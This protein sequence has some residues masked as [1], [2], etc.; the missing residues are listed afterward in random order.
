[1]DREALAH[2]SSW[3]C[4]ESDMT[5]WLNWTE[6]NWRFME[7]LYT[8]YLLF[9]ISG[10]PGG[11]NG[12]EPACQCRR[13]KRYWFHPWV[14]KIPWKGAQLPT[15]V[16][17]PGEPQDRG[18]WRAATSIGSQWGRTW[19][20]WLSTHGFLIL[21]GKNW[22]T[23]LRTFIFLFLLLHLRDFS[24]GLVKAL[25]IMCLC[26]SLKVF[27][28]LDLKI[29]FYFVNHIWVLIWFLLLNTWNVHFGSSLAYAYCTFI[30][31]VRV[32][33][34]NFPEFKSNGHLEKY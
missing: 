6:L 33:Y 30:E 5:E 31:H 12:K 20:K 13:H 1:M 18:A 25:E 34:V 15:P 19:L 2:C 14:R 24:L 7:V 22:L 16:F 27:D 32:S 11:A 17:L 26:I 3:V 10:F 8:E 23:L 9:L 4:K 29:F 21:H 28:Y